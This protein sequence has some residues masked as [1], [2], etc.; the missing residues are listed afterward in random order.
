MKTYRGSCHCGA[1]HFEADIDL[2]KG[3]MRCNCSFCLKIRCWAAIVPVDSFRLQLGEQELTEYQFG[4]KSERHF[5]CKHCGARPFGFV[6]SPRIGKFYAVSV[7]CL[8]NA[9]TDEFA[10]ASIRYLDGINDNWDTPPA[11]CRHL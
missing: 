10:G 5:F 7:T 6:N 3:T 9:S 4:A 8:D 11:E 1:V 2:S